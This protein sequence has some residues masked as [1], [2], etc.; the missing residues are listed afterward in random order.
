MKLGEGVFCQNLAEFPELNLAITVTVF[1][2]GAACQVLWE[3]PS[4][5]MNLQ[6]YFRSHVPLT[7]P[8]RIT[9]KFQDAPD[10][11]VIVEQGGLWPHQEIRA[12]FRGVIARPLHGET[13]GEHFCIGPIDV[14]KHS[15]VYQ[16]HDLKEGS[17]LI[18]QPGNL[19]LACGKNYLINGKQ[20]SS[21]DS[22]WSITACQKER[23]HVQAIEP[24]RILTYQAVPH[25]RMKV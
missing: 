6:T 14:K 1:K 15:M 2:P 11:D 22:P 18:V 8:F 21:S 23:A 17:S 5:P 3:D 13:T 12:G 16:K 7:G 25:S 24:C 10:E 19:L 9:Q 20:R 4:Q